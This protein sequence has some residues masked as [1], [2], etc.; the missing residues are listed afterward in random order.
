MTRISL[1]LL[2]CALQSFLSIDYQHMDAQLRVQG[3]RRMVSTMAACGSRGSAQIYDRRPQG[4]KLLFFYPFSSR[5]SRTT[6]NK[7][8]VEGFTGSCFS[9]W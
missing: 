7:S 6:Y 4:P 3:F 9:L 5:T 1:E 8:S 2:S